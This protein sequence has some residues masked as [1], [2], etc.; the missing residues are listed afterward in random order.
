M[1]IIWNQQELSTRSRWVRLPLAPTSSPASSI[2]AARAE[3]IW[4]EVKASS[5][6]EK[7]IHP[8]SNPSLPQL[9]G[10]EIFPATSS[11]CLF[12]LSRPDNTVVVSGSSWI[13]RWLVMLSG[14]HILVTSLFCFRWE[15]LGEIDS[16]DSSGKGKWAFFI[17]QYSLI[18][19]NIDCFLVSMCVDIRRD[20]RRNKKNKNN[21]QG[22]KGE[23]A[24]QRFVVALSTFVITY[25]LLYYYS[26]VVDVST[27]HVMVF[28]I[29]FL[30]CWLI[31]VFFSSTRLI[32][33]IK[34]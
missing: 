2:N 7:S 25:I 32:N 22:W 20:I 26:M 13:F 21:I 19:C 12:N 6:A 23:R 30:L 24:W 17:W 14:K 27:S 1:S 15:D 34:V 29:F 31:G 10:M 18:F 4:L 16:L 11:L 9:S 5:K 28:F 33:V 3:T 8:I